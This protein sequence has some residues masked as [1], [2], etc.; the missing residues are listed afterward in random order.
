M[1]KPRLRKKSE[2]LERGQKVTA[3]GAE[4]QAVRQAVEVINYWIDQR[5]AQ[6][7]DPRTAFAALF[8]RP[9]LG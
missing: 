7:K 5:R 1:T 3:E 9:Q 6:R 2:V 8:S 4:K